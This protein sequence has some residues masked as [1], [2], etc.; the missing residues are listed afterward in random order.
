M[1]Q[2]LQHKA[3][4]AVSLLLAAAAALSLAGC[5]TLWKYDPITDVNDLQGR[6]VGVNLAWESDYYLTPRTDMTL[7][8]Y[9]STGDMIMALSYDKV[10][11]VAIDD[12]MW[13]LMAS[14]S[15]GLARVEPA[16]GETGYI[17]YF[18]ADDEALSEDFNEFLSAYKTTEGYRDFIRR[19]KEFDGENYAEPDIPLTG[20][21]EALRVAFS[22]EDYPRSFLDAGDEIPYGFDLEML[23]H[24]ANDR[25]YRLEFY[26]SNYN[27]AIMSLLR[28]DYDIFTGYLGDVY[29]EEVLQS[30]LFTSDPMDSTPLYFVQ[31]TRQ[32][33]AV[34]TAALE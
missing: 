34:D 4:S 11:A 26:P 19:E 12:L 14:K 29:R 33:I 27:D 32:S 3:K 13:K 18:G 7:Y 16:F 28:N 8:R 22:P 23:K 21:G 25:N 2:L 5:A 31:K 1:R 24:Y 9:R 10:D 17:M 20:T 30:G 6:R 15:Q